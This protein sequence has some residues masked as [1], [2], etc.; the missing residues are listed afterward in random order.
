MRL[1]GPCGFSARLVS[2]LG[3]PL[4]NHKAEQ[5]GNVVDIPVQ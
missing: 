1:A 5:R 3:S 2:D 4:K